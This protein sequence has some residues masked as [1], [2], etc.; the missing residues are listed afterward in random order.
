MV[1]WPVRETDAT[2]SPPCDSAVRTT[3]DPACDE[4]LA[5]RCKDGQRSDRR[6]CDGIF[7]TSCAEDHE[8]DPAWVA[9]ALAGYP[10]DLGGE[11]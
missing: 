5:C 3:C 10:V 8:I 1:G 9:N 4:I 2:R 7:C 6:G 11:W